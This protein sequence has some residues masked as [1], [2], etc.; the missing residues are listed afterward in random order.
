MVSF[1][2]YVYYT[3]LASYCQA[4]GIVQHGL[5]H[6]LIDTLGGTTGNIIQPAQRQHRDHDTPG[7]T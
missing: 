3:I 1:L 4:G 7:C 5:P 2:A 6:T